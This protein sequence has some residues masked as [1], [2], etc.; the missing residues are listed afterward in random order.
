MW[1]A[2]ATREPPAPSIPRELYP[3]TLDCVH[4][5]LCLPVCPTYR[6]TGRETS[7]PRGRVYLMRGVAE[8]RIPLG[9][10]VAEEAQLC[11]GC[12]ACETA[13]PSGVRF[14]A[15]LEETRAAVADA[16]IRGGPGPKLERFLLRELVPKPRRLGA[17]L[18]LLRVAQQLRLDRLAARLLPAGARHLADG[19]PRVPSRSQRRPL[20]SVVPAEGETRGR[21]GFLVG[22]VMPEIFGAVNQATVRLLAKNGFEV[23]VVPGQGCCGALQAHAGQAELARELLDRNVQAFSGEGLDAVVSNSA[24]CGAF[25]R[26]AGDHGIA[27]GEEFAGHVRDVCEFLDAVG[28]RPPAPERRLRVAY[29]DPCHLVHGQG[30]SAAPRRLLQQIPG[31]ELVEHADPTSCCGAAGTYNLTQPEMSAA[32]LGRKIRSLRDASPDV[33]VSGNPG[34]LIQLQRGAREIGWDVQ[35]AHPVELLSG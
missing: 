14:G 29:D 25:L 17:A 21:V 18:S 28:M 27:G 10:V 16:G 11:L 13:C 20:P 34:C 8:G 30:V 7:S 31:V 19:A 4:C 35:I 26:E 5:G 12:R 22:C 24:G 6:E 23:H 32:V 2:P 9:E 1:E 33:V 15:L 3:K